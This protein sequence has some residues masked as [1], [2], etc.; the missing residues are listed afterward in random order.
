MNETG[1]NKKKNSMRKA[2]ERIENYEQWSRPWILVKMQMVQSVVPSTG[3][4]M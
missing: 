1:K 3:E 2:E 4:N